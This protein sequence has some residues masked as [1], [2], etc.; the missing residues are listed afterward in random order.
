MTAK[1]WKDER[2]PEQRADEFEKSTATVNRMLLDAID[3]NMN[4]ARKHEGIPHMVRMY[5]NHCRLQN[6][7]LLFNRRTLRDL[8]Q[9]KELPPR[10]V[11]KHPAKPH[12]KLGQPD[13]RKVR[14]VL[15]DS[16]NGN[17]LTPLAVALYEP[18]INETAVADAEPI[19]KFAARI[20]AK[21]SEDVDGKK[22]VKQELW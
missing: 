4:L 12:P 14:L 3:N 6:R 22:F 2:T 11:R 8:R 19:R 13:P 18:G 10:P 5:V 15:S 20:A 17:P 16:A 9:G 7:W 21:K 1:G